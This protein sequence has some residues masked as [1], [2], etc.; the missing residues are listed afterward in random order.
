MQCTFLEDPLY[1]KA[2]HYV[3]QQLYFVQA[4]LQLITQDVVKSFIDL[5]RTEFHIIS[6]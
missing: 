6:A 3:K 5:G 1:G 2:R 4:Q